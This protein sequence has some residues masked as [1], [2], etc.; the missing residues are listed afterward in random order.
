MKYTYKDMPD[1]TKE[2]I[3][4]EVDEGLLT[5]AVYEYTTNGIPLEMFNDRMKD[6]SRADQL[7]YYMRFRNEH[8]KLFK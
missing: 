1:K 7:F 4:Q 3:L 8:P 5:A 2:G 6:W